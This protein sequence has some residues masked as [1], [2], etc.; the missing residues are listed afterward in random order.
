MLRR[1]PRRRRAAGELRISTAARRAVET[2][3]VALRPRRRRPDGHRGAP[4]AAL[5]RGRGDLGARGARQPTR[6]NA[7]PR[8]LT[9]PTCCAPTRT[10]LG[11]RSGASARLRPPLRPGGRPTNS[12]VRYEYS[13]PGPSAATWPRPSTT[14]GHGR[15]GATSRGRHRTRHRRRLQ[16]HGRAPSDQRA[17]EGA[18]ARNGGLRRSS[19]ARRARGASAARC[20]STR[21]TACAA[22][23]RTRCSLVES[24]AA[25]SRPASAGELFEMVEAA[26]SAVGRRPST[27]CRTASRLRQRPRLMRGQPRGRG[28]GVGRAAG[29]S[30]RRC[31]DVL[32][33]GERRGCIVER[34]TAECRP[35]PEY[36]PE[37]LGRT[38]LVTAEPVVGESGQSARSRT[39][40]D[41][42]SCADGGRRGAS[43][44]RSSKQV[45]ESA[46]R[47]ET[48]RP[49]TQRDA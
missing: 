46:T 27:R 24:V 45:L 43:T 42:P 22:G 9:A 2:R 44:S 5:T 38:L 6:A 26:P 19:P 29:A 20:A 49:S 3:G 37:R 16:L 23:R 13:P 35:S 33:A 28:A 41:L 47:E 17:G 10:K 15:A 30:R 31:C 14:T 34:A 39:G 18:G 1:H 40:R 25:S 8:S 12:P 7:T 4:G 21:P 32:R 48:S 11:Q 36:T